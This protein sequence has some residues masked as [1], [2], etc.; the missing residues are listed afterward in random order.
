MQALF[1]QQLSVQFLQCY[2]SRQEVA[3]G[4]RPLSEFWMVHTEHGKICSVYGQLYISVSRTRATIFLPYSTECRLSCARATRHP[5]PVHFGCVGMTDSR[6]HANQE[7]KNLA[8]GGKMTVAAKRCNCRISGSEYTGEFSSTL[9]K[10]NGGLMSNPINS[11]SVI[12]SSP[13]SAF[14]SWM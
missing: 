1:I 6:V 14:I 11:L 3:D 9:M 7:M 4:G 2:Q 10:R 5:F 8:P 12:S 13:I